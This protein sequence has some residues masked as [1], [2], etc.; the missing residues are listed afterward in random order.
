MGMFRKVFGLGV[1]L[2]FGSGAAEAA[3]VRADRAVVSLRRNV[4]TLGG[5]IRGVAGHLGALAAALTPVT[6][7]LGLLIGKGSQLGMDLEANMLTMRVLLG[8]A[9]KASDLVDRIRKFAAATPFQEGDLIEGSKRLLRLT[10]Q[11]VD[12]NMRLLHVLG[13]VTALNPSKN[14]VEA[15]EAL[16]DA[17][18]G[19]GF[20]RLKEFGITLHASDFKVKAGQAG[21]AEAVSK[22][23]EED[24]KKL[25]RG[26][27]LVGELSKTMSGRLSTL[28]DAVSN[29]I[30]EIGMSLNAEIGGNIVAVGDYITNQVQPKLTASVRR[31]V[32]AVKGELRGAMPALDALVAWWNTQGPEGQQ[33]IYDIAVQVIGLAGAIGALVPLLGPLFFAFGQILGIAEQLW[34]VVALLFS[35]ETLPW[36]IGIA[37]VV[38]ALV[39]FQNTVG[40]LRERWNAFAFGFMQT[41][42]GFSKAFDPVVVQLRAIGGQVADLIAHLFGGEIDTSTWATFGEILAT[43]INGGLRMIAG[44]VG[45]V[46][47]FFDILRTA[48]E[49]SLFLGAELV[50]MFSD[51]YSGAKNA[52]T[53]ITGVFQLVGLMFA[54]FINSTAS[55]ALG[56]IETILRGIETMLSSNPIG[57]AVLEKFGGDL[58]SQ[59]LATIRR[60]LAAD[61]ENQIAGVNLAESRRDKAKSEATNPTINVEQAPVDVKV[62]VKHKTEIDGNEI[63]RSNGAAAV[64]AGKR[65]GNVL[66]SAQRARV[67]RGNGTITPLATAEVL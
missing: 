37:A 23:V 2:T 41:F 59:G 54:A 4:L 33:R 36:V 45:I 64:R 65:Q 11:N 5:S 50:R 67:L 1:E 52:G 66:P 49:P 29:M 17:T 58:G 24:I 53:G 51:W 30:R 16:L 15:V 35:T 14:I 12:E 56:V 22:R 63:A 13:N 61:I 43:M 25:T 18:S 6:L 20:E 26:Q 28:K 10:G 3:M 7:G 32:D 40:G 8:D 57:R 38:G 21:F 48:M 34:P 44:T 39:W 31:L 47:N 62:E 19:G 42:D 9:A 27:D 55:L 46:I 60:D